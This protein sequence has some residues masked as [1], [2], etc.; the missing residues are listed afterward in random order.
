MMVN[1]KWVKVGSKFECGNTECKKLTRWRGSVL[2]KGVRYC[3]HCY[4]SVTTV[5]GGYIPIEDAVKKV[6]T[7]SLNGNKCTVSLPICYAGKKVRVV[8]VEDD[9]EC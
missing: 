2:Y 8:V 4:H 3:N 9:D 6:R 5:I 7:V 1:G